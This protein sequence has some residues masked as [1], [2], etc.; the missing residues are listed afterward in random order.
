MADFDEIEARIRAQKAKDERDDEDKKRKVREDFE[1]GA[2]KASEK[3]KAPSA[4]AEETGKTILGEVLS[5]VGRATGLQPTNAPGVPEKKKEFPDLPTPPQM[6][7]ES[8]ERSPIDDLKE[9][10]PG[11]DIDKIKERWGSIKGELNE[12]GLLPGAK[13]EPV[14]PPMGPPVP[15]EKSLRTQVETSLT[16]GGDSPT[17]PGKDRTVRI[18][19]K[20]TLNPGAV[21]SHFEDITNELSALPHRDR[22]DFS[23][24]MEELRSWYSK[25]RDRMENGEL[26]ERLAHAFTQLGAGIWGLKSG[27]DMSGLK[28]DKA[29]WERKQDRLLNEFKVRL[30]EL[31]QRRG[32]AIAEARHGEALE[33]TRRGQLMDA[34]RGK[35]QAKSVA[36]S[37]ALTAAQISQAGQIAATQLGLQGEQ[38][39]E[40]IRHNRAM[41]ATAAAKAKGSLDLKKLNKD[42]DDTMKE[43]RQ[44]FLKD[45]GTADE[46]RKKAAAINTMSIN[47]GIDAAAL[48]DALSPDWAIDPNQEESLEILGEVAKRVKLQRLESVTS[49]AGNGGGDGD[50]ELVE[51]QDPKTGA[52]LRVPKS[53]YNKI[54]G[55]K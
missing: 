21:K 26:A 22:K 54:T 51:V 5:R 19:G 10:V 1:R 13:D 8:K 7:A 18:G 3:M 33:M 9:K 37:Q 34:A 52:K 46:D 43:V 2:A 47:L 20:V 55:G 49:G 48:K 44:I 16:T 35:D 39:D 17:P 41:E 12:K 27:V 42:V 53:V 31:S 36:M 6:S 15:S 30:D 45:D 28:F 4:T 40:L 25:A 32:E 23:N 50:D 14:K 29:D 11:F 38:L 24:D